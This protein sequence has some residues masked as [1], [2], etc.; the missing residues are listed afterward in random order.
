MRQR[1]A[2]SGA[3]GQVRTGDPSFTK[4]DDLDK[5]RIHIKTLRGIVDATDDLGD[6]HC[7]RV[8]FALDRLEREVGTRVAT[9]DRLYGLVESF[10]DAFC[11]GCKWAWDNKDEIVIVVNDV[12]STYR[13]AKSAGLGLPVGET[14]LPSL[15]EPKK[16]EVVE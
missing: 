15:P 4:G 5:I 6:R 9:S 12:A 14:N 2:W 7:K 16:D 3:P 11:A 13:K 8:Q 1:A 10:G